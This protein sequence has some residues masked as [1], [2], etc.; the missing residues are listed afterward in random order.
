VEVVELLGGATGDEPAHRIGH[1][2]KSITG[3]WSRPEREQN[4]CTR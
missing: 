4:A 3:S 1:A 2:E